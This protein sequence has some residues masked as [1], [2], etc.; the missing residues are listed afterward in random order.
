MLGSFGQN[1]KVKMYDNV[2]DFRDDMKNGRGTLYFSNGQKVEG[3]FFEDS[4]HGYGKYYKNN[5]EII[6]GKW[7]NNQLLY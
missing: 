3:E 6:S 4:I 7:D 5:G 2:G 1:M